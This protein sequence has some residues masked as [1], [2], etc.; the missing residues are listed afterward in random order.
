MR[1]RGKSIRRKIVALLLV[2]LVSLTA[3]WGFTTYI[4]GREANEL[5]NVTYIVDKVGSPMED[6]VQVIQEERRQTLVYLA[7]QRA[8]DALAAL[9][10]RRR[11]TDRAVAKIRSAADDS[12][13]RDDLRPAARSRLKTVLQE[14]D[15]IGDLRRQIDRRSVNRTQALEA[16]SGVIEPCYTFLTNLHALENVD[17]DKQGRAVVGLARAREMLAREDALIASSLVAPPQ[18][19]W[20]ELREVVNLVANRT[21]LYEISLE[22]LPGGE[23]EIFERFWAAA[24]SESLRAA[25]QN[26][27]TAAPPRT[28]ASTWPAGSRPRPRCSRVSRRPFPT[29]TTA[30]ATASTRSPST[31]SSRPVS[32][33]S[34]ASSPWSSR[35]SSPSVSAA[36]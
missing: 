12:Q 28:R 27:I 29:P 18:F 3:L 10:S 24:G 14:F 7:D 2:P 16:Y 26:I 19:T 21:L 5:L 15:G 35:S 30:T 31:S 20:N 6:T 33:A 34:S 23:R 13:V 1:F 36:S 32:R 11:D 8:S 17:M 4:T 22:N 25:E 9:Q